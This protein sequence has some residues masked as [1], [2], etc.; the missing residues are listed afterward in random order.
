MS[1]ITPGN[2]G[3]AQST[4]LE[5]LIHELCSIIINAENDSAKNPEGLKNFTATHYQNR[6]TY[7]CSFIIPVIQVANSQSGVQYSA[8]EYLVNTGFTPGVS[9]T[10]TNNGLLSTLFTALLFAQSYEVNSTS[11]P[12]QINN[13]TGKIDTDTFEFVGNIDLEVIQTPIDSGIVGYE[14]IPYLI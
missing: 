11:N 10:F 7:S 2:G 1:Q 12:N 13:I 14:V 3:T 9:G 8:R 6:G 5:A 4:T